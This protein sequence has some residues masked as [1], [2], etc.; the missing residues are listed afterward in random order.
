MR[1]YCILAVTVDIKVGQKLNK[2]TNSLIQK[3]FQ[4]HRKI[5]KMW[6]QSKDVKCCIQFVTHK[7]EFLQGNL[8]TLLYKKM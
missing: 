3:R 4:N 6:I 2:L 5:T 1:D 7:Q 8:N